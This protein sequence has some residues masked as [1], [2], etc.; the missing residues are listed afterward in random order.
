MDCDELLENITA[1][2]EGKLTERRMWSNVHVDKVACRSA[3]KLYIAT[4]RARARSSGSTPWTHTS[5]DLSTL[6]P[7]Q[8][9]S[10]FLPLPP[11][12]L[13]LFNRDHF[14]CH[15]A[16]RAHPFSSRKISER[17]MTDS[18]PTRPMQS[19]TADHG[20]HRSRPNSLSQTI[21]VWSRPRRLQTT[22]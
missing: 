19:V 5:G 21:L 15:A 6:S 7:R 10:C 17:T 3:T 13:R 14:R 16:Q 8:V 22:D 12:L 4:R 9:A 1:A 18:E 20:T 11:G 2:S